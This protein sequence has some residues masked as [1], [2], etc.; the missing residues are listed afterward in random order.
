MSSQLSLPLA[1]LLKPI[2][3]QADALLLELVDGLLR[4]DPAWKE[5]VA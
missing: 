1:N 3:L 5:A 4:G 2:V